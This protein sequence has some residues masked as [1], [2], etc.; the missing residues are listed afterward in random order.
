LAKRL[1]AVRAACAPTALKLRMG[2]FATSQKPGSGGSE[3]IAVTVSQR[4]FLTVRTD[5]GFFMTE[6]RVTENDDAHSTVNHGEK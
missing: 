5:E 2:E 3:R 6:N 1:H 4:A